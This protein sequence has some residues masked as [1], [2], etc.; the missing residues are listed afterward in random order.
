MKKKLLLTLA[1]CAVAGFATT[2]GAGCDM[3]SGNQG[4]TP[5]QGTGDTQTPDDDS[6]GNKT[7]EDDKDKPDDGTGTPEDTHTKHTYTEKVAEEKYLK[8]KTTCTDKAVYYYSCTCGEKGTETFEYGEVDK[9]N[10]HDY[11]DGICQNCG[12][13]TLPATEGLTYELNEDGTGYI[14]TGIGTATDSKIVIAS[15]YGENNLPVTEIGERAFYELG[16]IES[17]VIPHSV[18]TIG[19]WAFAICWN[20]TSLSIPNSVTYIGDFAFSNLQKLENLTIPNSV[21]HIGEGAFA[22]CYVLKNIQIPSSVESIGWHVFNGCPAIESITVDSNNLHYKSETNCLLTKDG[23]TLVAGCKNSVI[24]N[25]VTNIGIGSFSGSTFT[26]IIIPDSVTSIGDAAFSGCEN[27]TSI[28]LSGN[29]TSIGESAFQFCENLTDIC[30]P[31]GVMSIG[32]YAFYECS[33]LTSIIIPESVTSVGSCVF[34]YCRNLTIYCEAT[35]QPEGWHNDWNPDNRPVI[36]GGGSENTPSATEGLTYELNE[37]GTGYIVTGLG[38]ATDTDI[39]IPSTYGED[40]LPVTEIGEMAFMAAAYE[41]DEYNDCA[42]ITSFTIP[43]SVTSIGGAAFAGCVSL[44]TFTIPET[45]AS[46]GVGVFAMCSRLTSVNLP[47]NLTEIPQSMFALCENLSSITIPESVTS[48]GLNAFSSCTGLKSI[49]IPKS[50][51]YIDEE[52]FSGCD[53]LTI[54]C[55]AESQPE[56][57]NENWNMWFEGNVEWGYKGED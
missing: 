30:I 1:L 46:I 55:E 42:K 23:K 24:P 11:K 14:A 49:I 26:S 9:V 16:S 56:E 17:I 52:A 44:T 28:T 38:T 47:D 31:S 51:T 21:T 7:P 54:Y 3:L 34:E 48:I 43:S 25:G 4:E 57:W 15:T 41:G 6:D 32:D 35:S 13:V 50:V 29:L 12:D 20:A 39:V 10:G 5:D 33:G 2:F 53:N 19:E 22:G 36:W 27:I 37:D 45:V 18:T 8:S 40:N